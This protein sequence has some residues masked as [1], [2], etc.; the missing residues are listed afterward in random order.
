MRIALEE[1]DVAATGGDIPVGCVIVGADGRELGRGGNRREVDADPTAHAEVVALRAAAKA[2]GTWKLVDATLYVTLEPCT[3]CAGAIVNARVARVVYG[4]ADPKAGAIDS[5]YGVGTDG[6]LDHQIRVE[7][8]YL[9]GA[10]LE[11]LRRF[12]AA[13]RATGARSPT[14]PE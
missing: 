3:M 7:G 1:A 12:F 8:G 14:T 5:V 4:V 9:R 6:K 10:C 2:L 13:L 11:R